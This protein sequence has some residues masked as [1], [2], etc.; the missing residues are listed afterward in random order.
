MRNILMN[1]S[2]NL[3][4]KGKLILLEKKKWLLFLI[5]N[6]RNV[7]SLSDCWFNHIFSKLATQGSGLNLSPTIVASVSEP[8]HSC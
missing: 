6:S 1:V 5:Q 3:Y 8:S 7:S 4:V 2:F